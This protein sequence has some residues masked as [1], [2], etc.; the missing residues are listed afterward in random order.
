MI[1]AIPV[2]VDCQSLTVHPT[3][4]HLSIGTCLE[5]TS[6]N[7]LILW[8]R[9][10]FHSPLHSCIIITIP[11]T[12]DEVFI[13]KSRCATF[14][15]CLFVDVMYLRSVGG[16]SLHASKYGICTR[17]SCSPCPHVAQRMCLTSWFYSIRS[18]CCSSVCISFFSS[19]NWV[20]AV[21][22]FVP[23]QT[24]LYGTLLLPVCKST[25][26]LP[27]W[28]SSERLILISIFGQQHSSSVDIHTSRPSATNLGTH[29]FPPTACKSQGMSRW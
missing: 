15:R 14:A 13:H 21:N 8:N 23:T 7:I 10:V 3:A 28:W 26:L 11:I 29:L 6:P 20:L 17:S 9:P 22:T 19:Q 2:Y 18:G 12:T 1:I 24:W 27:I 25:P 4:T 16:V 5:T